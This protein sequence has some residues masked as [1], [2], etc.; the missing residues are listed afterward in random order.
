MRMMKSQFMSARGKSGLVV[1]CIGFGLT[2]PVTLADEPQAASSAKASQAAAQPKV[3]KS[4]ATVDLA[5]ASPDGFGLIIFRPAAFFHLP[6]MK[7]LAGIANDLIATKVLHLDDRKRLTL[8]V[9]SIEQITTEIVSTKTDQRGS[10]TFSFGT[11]ARMIRMTE[12]FDWKKQFQSLASVFDPPD[13]VMANDRTM[14][15]G[16]EAKC[17]QRRSASSPEFNRCPGWKEVEHCIAVC[18]LNNSRSQWTKELDPALRDFESEAEGRKAVRSIRDLSHVIIGIDLSEGL[19]V[20]AFL[21]FKTEQAARS[22]FD[23]YEAS[24][25]EMRKALQEA[26]KPKIDNEVEKAI[27]YAEIDLVRNASV[28]R[29]GNVITVHSSA[30]VAL[31]DQKVQQALASLIASR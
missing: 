1:I 5:Y 2:A 3:L 6:G 14:V 9:D 18:V 20:K 24:L 16:P 19:V 10:V 30:K 7:S 21:N 28:R 27:V 4:G 29:E 31:A 22:L 25:P 13:Y 12:P 26:G 15:L 23:Q 8:S 17:Q 11:T